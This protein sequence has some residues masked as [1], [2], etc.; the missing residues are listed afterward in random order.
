MPTEKMQLKQSFPPVVNSET[1]IL[2]LGSLPGDVSL[3]HQ[4]YYAHPQN[5]FWHLLSDIISLD[6]VGL[7]YQFRLQTLLQYRIGLWDVVAQAQRKGSLDSQIRQAQENNLPHLISSLPELRCIA[8][9]GNTAAKI[10]QRILSD[11][12]PNTKTPLITHVLP[13]SSPAFTKTYEF[14]RDAWL[15]LREYLAR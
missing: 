1:R 8:F 10:G 3:K 12:V 7:T 13:S 4:E 2:I 6:L 15:L 9:N 5:R 11:C 14:K